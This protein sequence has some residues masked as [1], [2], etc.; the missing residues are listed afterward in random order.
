[1]MVEL[2]NATCVIFINERRRQSNSRKIKTKVCEYS[3]YRKE[4]LMLST[5]SEP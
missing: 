2:K 4:K 5:E 3:I 1:M